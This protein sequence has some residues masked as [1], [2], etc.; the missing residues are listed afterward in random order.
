MAINQI[1]YKLFEDRAMRFGPYVK[2][3]TETD[4]SVTDIRH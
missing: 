4:E 2:F 3:S 1:T